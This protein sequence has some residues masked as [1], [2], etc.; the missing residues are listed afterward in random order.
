M[1][2]FYQINLQTVLIHKPGL[3]G[4][5]YFQSYPPVIDKAGNIYISLLNQQSLP[6][7]VENYNDKSPFVAYQCIFHS[8]LDQIDGFRIDWIPAFSDIS[9]IRRIFNPNVPV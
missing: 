3:S 7:P 8:F 6:Q 1:N 4:G 5:R 2:L 9:E